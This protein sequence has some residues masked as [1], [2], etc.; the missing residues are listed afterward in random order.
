MGSGHILVSTD[1]GPTGQ[2]I[3]VI[4]LKIPQHVKVQ[5]DLNPAWSASSILIPL[6]MLPQK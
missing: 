3:G 6:N 1:K 5:L 4:C 2:S